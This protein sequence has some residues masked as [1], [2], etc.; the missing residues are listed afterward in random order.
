MSGTEGTPFPR[1]HGSE[2]SGAVRDRLGSLRS[3]TSEAGRAFLAQICVTILGAATLVLTAR[4]L[5]PRGQGEASTVLAL[6]VL[7]GVTIGGSVLPSVVHLSARD[8]GAEELRAGA[9]VVGVTTGGLLGLVFFL[10]G[11]SEAVRSLIG[12][13]DSATVFAGALV[14]ASA[15][16]DRASNGLLRAR[17][18][19][20]AS[21]VIDVAES[22][23]VL[24]IVSVLWVGNL[25]TP[26]SAVVA[27]GLGVASS[28]IVAAIGAGVHRMRREHVRGAVVRAIS[29]FGRPVWMGYLVQYG[30]YRLD[31]IL[32]NSIAGPGAAGSYAVAARLSETVG[33]V[34]AA[35]GQVVSP[36]SAHLDRP[37]LAAS[38]PRI[39]W[40]VATVS[41]ILGAT[42]AVLAP[43]LIRLLFGE[44]FEGV[45]T[46]AQVLL[47]A[48]VVLA[49]TRVLSEELVQIGQPHV[50]L[51]NSVIAFA[52]GCVAW[53][54]LIP[55][56]GALGASLGSLVAY[57]VNAGTTVAAYISRMPLTTK[58]F[59]RSAAFWR[60]D[61]PLR[62]PL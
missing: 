48:V 18:L 53:L 21:S 15:P 35:A 20:T 11:L 26:A 38:T 27:Y 32:L 3:F 51:R 58:Q 33:L 7:L 2:Q 34:P 39:F 6:A 28:G 54:I 4:D 31:L 13:V 55:A 19:V 42:A 5:G 16:I 22:V 59:F 62:R 17:G 60:G 24:V 12:E 29:R 56:H 23:V 9:M 50:A 61:T 37:E 46:T 52:V 36:R 14:A 57:S 30:L 49:P 43:H 8:V 47:M 1:P 45:T 41:A 44:G 40:A 25:L 10:A